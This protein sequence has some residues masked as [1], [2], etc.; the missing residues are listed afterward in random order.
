MMRRVSDLQWSGWN[1]GWSEG[2]HENGNDCFKCD[3]REQTI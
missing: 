2:D 1:E 3:I